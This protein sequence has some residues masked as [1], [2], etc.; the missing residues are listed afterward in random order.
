MSRGCGVDDPAVGE[1]DDTVGACR[2]RRVVRDVHDGGAGPGREGRQE[3]EDLGAASRVEHRRR[4]VGDE[5]G[6][7]PGHGGRDGQALQ[8]SAGQGIGARR[9]EAGEADPS[10]ECLDVNRV[11]GRQSPA[12]VLADGAPD[13]LRLGTL[14][15][16]RRPAG[17]PEPDAAGTA[18]PAAG[19]FSAGE[20]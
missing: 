17:Q 6:R 15:H 20:Q 5:Q 1:A 10:E 13:H 18:D 12:Q 8:L 4:F 9:S 19:G 14:R 2:L 11:F 16:D 3:V 7:A